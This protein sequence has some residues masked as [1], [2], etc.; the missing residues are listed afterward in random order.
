MANNFSLKQFAQNV[1]AQKVKVPPYGW[2]K[3]NAY[4]PESVN[5][6]NENDYFEL[7]AMSD[8][9]L[10]DVIKSNAIG[11]PMLMPLTLQLDEAGAKTF[12]LHTNR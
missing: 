10:T 8:E 1:L 5:E 6:V 7:D 11:R 4:L 9:E 3:N 12:T 2:F